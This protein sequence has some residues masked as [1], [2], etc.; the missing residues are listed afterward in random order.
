MAPLGRFPAAA[1]PWRNAG[2][3]AVRVEKAATGFRALTRG[4]QMA[5]RNVYLEFVVNAAR[6][7]LFP[8]LR[9]NAIASVWKS[10]AVVVEMCQ[11]SLFR[12]T[13]CSNVKTV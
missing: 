5:G 4:G 3:A 12:V 2:N 10:D 1:V 13:R 8:T 11:G 7:E 9:C 6:T